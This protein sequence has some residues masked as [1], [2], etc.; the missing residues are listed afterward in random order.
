MFTVTNTGDAPLVVTNGA[1]AGADPGQFEEVSDT[2]TGTTVAPAATC[3]VEVRYA[4]VSIGTH[5][6]VLRFTHNAVSSPDDVA[7][8]G[9]GREVM[10]PDRDNDAVPDSTD[11]CPTVANPGQADTDGDGL[12]DACDDNPP[13]DIDHDN[14]PIPTD[15]CPTIYNPGQADTD[16]DDIGNACENTGA[17]KRISPA[18]NTKNIRRTGNDRIAIRAKTANAAVV[19]LYKIVGK[20]RRVLIDTGRLNENGAYKTVIKDTNGNRRTTYL[21]VVSP[22]ADTQRGTTQRR[23][24]S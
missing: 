15:N 7:L 12:G 2:C 14:V 8:R 24:Q 4:P 21:A 11:N 9:T 6:A 18:I 16:G 5:T 22:T 13:R 20:H 19:K 23:R 17:K 1:L 3:A 10:T